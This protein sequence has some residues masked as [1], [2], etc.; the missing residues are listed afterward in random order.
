MYR[1]DR[2]IDINE[3]GWIPY[4]FYPWDKETGPVDRFDLSYRSYL[5]VEFMLGEL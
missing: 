5:A 3:L 2:Y 1:L 4:S